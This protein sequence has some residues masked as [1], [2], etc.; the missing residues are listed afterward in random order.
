MAICEQKNKG[1]MGFTLEAMKRPIE[2]LGYNVISELAVF[3]IFDKGT[4]KEDQDTLGQASGLG[5]KLANL[6]C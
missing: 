1:D 2:A 6:M 3:R 4:V 5:K